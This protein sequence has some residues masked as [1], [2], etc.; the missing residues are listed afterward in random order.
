MDVKDQVTQE[1]YE[2]LE[3]IFN[4]ARNT[5]QEKS[6]PN[7]QNNKQFERNDKKENTR[8]NMD[9]TNAKESKDKKIPLSRLSHKELSET[10]NKLKDLKEEL[11]DNPSKYNKQLQ[12]IYLA[13][14]KIDNAM[15]KRKEKDINKSVQTLN[16]NPRHYVLKVVETKGRLHTLRAHLENNPR[17]NKNALD[18]INKLEKKL[19]G[20]IENMKTSQ[21]NK[22]IYVVQKNPKKYNQELNKYKDIQKKLNHQKEN[23]KVNNL[24]KNKEKSNE[25]NRSKEENKSKEKTPQLSM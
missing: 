22:A 25:K 2:I 21:I 7:N 11:K 23:D 13:E 17:K 6:Q 20:N 9:K 16:K 24:D 3:D 8:M 19:D 12:Q 18:K 5:Q 15:K 1:L 4:K 14:N 10:K